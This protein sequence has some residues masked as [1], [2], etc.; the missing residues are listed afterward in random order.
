MLRRL[1]IL[2]PLFVALLAT[3]AGCAATT[4]GGDD[5]TTDIARLSEGD[6]TV[7]VDALN[8]REQPNTSSRVLAVMPNGARVH[9]KGDGQQDG[10]VPVT[11]GEQEGWAWAEYLTPSQ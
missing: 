7:N 8:L 6:A 11:Y 3:V 1:P 9:V 10:F 5:A 2:A 4:D